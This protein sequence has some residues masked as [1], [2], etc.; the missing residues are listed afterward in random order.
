MRF[1]KAKALLRGLIRRYGLRLDPGEGNR[2]A[3]AYLD[4]VAHAAEYDSAR[5]IV[6]RTQRTTLWCPRIC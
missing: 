3:I 6:E 4:V 5:A 1:A 2:E